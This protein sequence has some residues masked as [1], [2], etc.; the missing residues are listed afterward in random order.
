MDR[1]DPRGAAQREPDLD[2][3]TGMTVDVWWARI[4]QARDE[5]ATDL[6]AVE[7]ERLA[8]YI[9]A[10]DRKRFLLGCTMVRRLLAARFSLP[11]AS[12]RLDRTCPRCGKPHGKVRAD[13]VELSVTHAGD[14][15][16]VAISDRPVGI[17]VEKVDPHL[18]VDGLAK[19]ALIPEEIHELS[20]HDENEK[21]RAF[22]RYWTRR[23]AAVKA[24][25]EGLPA[26][27]GKITAGIQL[28]EL[29]V[30]PD[31]VAALAVVS[32]EPPVV[33]TFRFGSDPRR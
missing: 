22:L 13:G 26:K 20:R 28:E 11:A 4:D 15:V 18:D 23:E 31:H 8:A 6:D 17:D 32:A 29:D 30:D 24:T 14:L 33:R 7:R 27:P 9:H 10:D 3:R 12:I 1:R 16:G 25:G 19:V 21:V 2:T 5:F